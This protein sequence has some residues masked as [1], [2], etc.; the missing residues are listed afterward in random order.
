MKTAT[1]KFYEMTTN[2]LTYT[3][4]TLPILMIMSS[5]DIMVEMQG[6]SYNY[7]RFGV[8]DVAH[9]HG[10]TSC[11]RFKH[12]RHASSLRKETRTI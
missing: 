9:Q 10:Q 11:K 8:F 6:S 2:G 7:F 12:D 3:I 4:I 5:G 1:F